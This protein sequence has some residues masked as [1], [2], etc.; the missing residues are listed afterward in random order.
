MARGI[1]VNV[2]V[3]LG[4]KLGLIEDRIAFRKLEPL[5]KDLLLIPAGATIEGQ[6]HTNMTVVVAGTM[7]GTINIRGDAN[8]LVL[9]EGSVNNGLVSANYLEVRGALRNASVDVDRVFVAEK[10]KILG[11]SR[12]RYDKLGKHDDAPIS[13]LLEKR[14]SARDGFVHIPR[15][16]VDALES[17]TEHHEI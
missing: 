8:M 11:K 4:Y 13:G 14:K 1:A 16:I 6:I 15:P 3:K 9:E 17:D 12:I 5:P 10:G 2:L 7:D